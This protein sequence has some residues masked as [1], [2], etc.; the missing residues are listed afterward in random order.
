MLVASNARFGALYANF[1]LSR[2]VLT[3]AIATTLP[4]RSVAFEP[5]MKVRVREVAEKTQDDEKGGR[6]RPLTL[7]REPGSE[8]RVKVRSSRRKIR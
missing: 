1:E 7:S 2:E 3:P 6:S 5:Q 4:V 8:L